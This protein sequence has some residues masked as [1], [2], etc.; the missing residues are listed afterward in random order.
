MIDIVRAKKAFKEYVKKY[1]PDDSKVKLK[2]AHIERTAEVAKK[3]ATELMLEKEDI[4]KA[5]SNK[6]Y[7]NYELVQGNILDTLDD[8]L[9]RNPHTKIS[10]LHI[11]TDVYEPAKY[12]LEKL[13]DKVVKG[14]VI[15]FDDYATIEGETKAIDEFFHDSNYIL[16]KFTFS[17]TKPSYIIKE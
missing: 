6:G 4:E 7:S 9:N 13:F 10:L 8:Y 14:G 17:H 5:L 16:K 1:N 3:L 12:A 11:D 15:V 2:I